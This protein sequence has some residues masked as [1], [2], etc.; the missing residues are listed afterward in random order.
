MASCALYSVPAIR[1][2]NVN[3]VVLE[4]SSFV[5][6][7]PE[8]VLFS[9]SLN[10]STFP[11]GFV[12]VTMIEELE[13]SL[14]TEMGFAFSGSVCVQE[15]ISEKKSCITNEKKKLKEEDSLVY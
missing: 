6:E 10:I 13:P 14:P 11:E 9:I 1:L 8:S 5:T 12:H 3:E 4:F 2:S 15:R 7:N